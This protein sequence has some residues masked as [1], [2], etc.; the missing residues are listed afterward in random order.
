MTPALSLENLVAWVLQVSSI[1]FAGALLPAILRLR[2]PRVH[3]YYCYGLLALC[4]ALPLVQPFRRLIWYSDAVPAAEALT[5]SSV[6]LMA[7][8]LTSLSRVLPWLLLGGVV[9]RFSLIAAGALRIRQYRKTAVPLHFPKESILSVCKLLERDVQIGVSAAEVGPVT[10]GWFRPMI[11]LPASFLS[12]DEEAQR[13]VLCHELL[14]VVRR[15][16]PATQVEEMIGAAL[17]F[18]PAILWLLAQARLAREELVD[19]EVVRLT[20]ARDSYIRALLSIAGVGR[21]TTL[22]AAPLFLQRRHL[23]ARLRTLLHDRASSDRRALWGYPVTVALVVIV[24]AASFHAFPL[25]ATPLADVAQSASSDSLAEPPAVLT[26]DETVVAPR[27]AHYI[28]PSYSDAA[29]TARVEGTVVLETA[30]GVDG[31]PAGLRIVRSLDPELDRN[32]IFALQQWRFEPARRDGGAVETKLYIEMR[33]QLTGPV[34]A[35]E[36]HRE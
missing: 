17:W 20:A 29:R 27:I 36:H 5:A 35:F 24:S 13:A 18:H 26:L 25:V 31:V 14:H 16:W 19:A 9:V 3:L 11:L 2:H 1:V 32:A 8:G 22:A 7:R 21:E 23:T 15:D 10:F 33:F 34:K 12:L 4:I 28:S 6:A 30:I